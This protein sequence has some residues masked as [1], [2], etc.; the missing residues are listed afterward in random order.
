M[1][2]ISNLNNKQV[3]TTDMFPKKFWSNSYFC[4]LL[5]D[6]ERIDVLDELRDRRIGS[7]RTISC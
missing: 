4:L 6:E 1:I 3:C 2:S 7:P 5:G